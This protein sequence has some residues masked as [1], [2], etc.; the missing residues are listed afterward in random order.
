MQITE[1]GG[2]TIA[3][4][5]YRLDAL[6]PWHRGLPSA[7]IKT[8]SARSI[9]DMG[10]KGPEAATA[11]PGEP[12][13]LPI[14]FL[15]ARNGQRV[16]PGP[17]RPQPAQKVSGYLGDNALTRVPVPNLHH[18]NRTANL[19]HQNRTVHPSLPGASP[20]KH[21][22][23]DD[24]AAALAVR[25]MTASVG[26]WSGCKWRDRV[27]MRNRRSG[28]TGGESH[29]CPRQLTNFECEQT[30]DANPSS[31]IHGLQRV[32]GIRLDQPKALLFSPSPLASG[33]GEL[34]A[35]LSVAP[36]QSVEGSEKL[37]PI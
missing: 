29:N 35:S 33:S 3:M 13:L 26:R 34:D 10:Q 19:H 14:F 23:P 8:Q 5:N 20:R 9:D 11:E 27:E 1:D 30:D 4:I 2:K 31:K 15:V 17:S 22:G 16:H 21:Q 7:I 6:R 32:Q 28:D 18:Q 24:S 12:P 37:T 25:V 36:D